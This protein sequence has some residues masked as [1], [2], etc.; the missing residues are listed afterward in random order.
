MDQYYILT[1]QPGISNDE[2]LISRYTKRD[3]YG[4][5][6]TVYTIDN[7]ISAL[8]AKTQ[9]ENEGYIVHIECPDGLSIEKKHE[10]ICSGMK[11]SS[12]K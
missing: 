11:I 1:V 9:F 7:K 4:T 12:N 8:K 2:E 6:M 5:N 3:N 10:V